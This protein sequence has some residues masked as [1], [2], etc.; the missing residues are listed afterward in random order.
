VEA[1]MIKNVAELDLRGTTVFLRV[2][3]NVP[4][5]QRGGDTV[6]AVTAAGAADRITHLSTGAC[7]T[8]EF[9]EGRELPGI[10]AFEEVT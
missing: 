6:A 4:L 1:I 2:D 7:A 10:R 3:F 8:L 9:L 5:D